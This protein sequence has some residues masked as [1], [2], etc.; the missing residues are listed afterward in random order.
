MYSLI[1]NCFSTVFTQPCSAIRPFGHKS[2]NK[3]NICVIINRIEPYLP[4]PSSY[5]WYSFT[6]SG[7]ME[8]ELT[9][10]AG[11]VVR[12]FKCPR[13]VTHPT[14]NRAQCRATALIETNMLPLH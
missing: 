14:T 5:S 11:Y 12:Q 13:A 10:V 3:I 9:W 6:D 2:E 1:L 7:G 4:L 8:A